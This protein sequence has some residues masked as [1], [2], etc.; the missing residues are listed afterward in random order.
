LKYLESLS[1]FNK[2]YDIDLYLDNIEYQVNKPKRFTKEEYKEFLLNEVYNMNS[3]FSGCSSLK[4]LPNI[5]KWDIKNSTDIS[6]M[7]AGCESL[8]YLP[9][10]SNWKNSEHY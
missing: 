9:D 8:I 1:K 4:Y 7:F 3:L 6:Y 10:I 2:S 5:S